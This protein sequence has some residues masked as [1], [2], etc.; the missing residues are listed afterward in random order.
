MSVLP[1][2]LVLAA[3]LCLLGATALASPPQVAYE[4]NLPQQSLADSLRAIGRQTTTNIMFEP[5]T[6]EN[7]TAPP[8]Q[9]RLSAEDAIKRVLTGTR[10]MAEQTAPNS[11]VVAEAPATSRTTSPPTSRSEWK[12]EYTRLAQADTTQAPEGT[13]G[14]SEP[15]SNKT[16]SSG[17]ESTRAPE[18]QTEVVVTGSRIARPDLDRLQPTT[19]ISSKVF[20][21]R[22]YNDAGQALSELPAFG[23]QPASADRKSVV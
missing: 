20:D 6:V 15:Q 22:G 19:V 17:P 8:V 13:S 12:T 7:L 11:V 16:E 18:P 3:I 14:K 10:L 21:E 1:V 5:Q 9:G 4:F 23:V 2:R